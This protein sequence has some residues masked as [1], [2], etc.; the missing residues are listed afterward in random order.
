MFAIACK[1]MEIILVAWAKRTMEVAEI[2]RIDKQREWHWQRDSFPQ[3]DTMIL[4][5][6]ILFHGHVS[7]H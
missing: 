7:L 3:Y 1:H 4:Q 5:I 2:R 6:F